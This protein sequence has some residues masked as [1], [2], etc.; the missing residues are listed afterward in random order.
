MG[1]SRRIPLLPHLSIFLSGYCF[2][3]EVQFGHRVAL[4]GICVEQKGHSFVV[5]AAGTTVYFA[6]WRALICAI[7][8]TIK[9]NTTAAI[10]IKV[11]TVLMKVP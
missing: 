6:F 8:R 9:K 1:Q 2:S 4:T 11:M 5:G 10:I 7:G 3:S